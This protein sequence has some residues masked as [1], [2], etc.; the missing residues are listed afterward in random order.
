MCSSFNCKKL[1]HSQDHNDSH[2]NSDAD[3]YD[4][5]MEMIEQK[6]DHDDEEEQEFQSPQVLRRSARTPKPI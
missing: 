3:S 6:G 4:H 1:V 5:S 2:G